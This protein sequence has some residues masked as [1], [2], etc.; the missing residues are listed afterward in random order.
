MRYV[1]FLKGINVADKHPVPMRDLKKLLH[2]F[3]FNNVQT[4]HNNGNV[5]FDN[6]LYPRNNLNTVIHGAIKD[7]FGFDIYVFIRS[8]IAMKQL[9]N[10]NPFLS[11]S[12][13]D[14]R[15]LYITFLDEIPSP[16]KIA[17]FKKIIAEDNFFIDGKH[18]YIH[19]NKKLI[20]SKLSNRFI[21]NSLGV[22]CTSRKWSTIEK[23]LTLLDLPADK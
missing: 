6:L 8:K 3:N 16:H 18:I 19:S 17:Y 4:I 20:N 2:T 7:F 23:S 9:K 21:G 13:I 14:I 15:K 1:A 10:N 22:S 5:V 11:K 12:N